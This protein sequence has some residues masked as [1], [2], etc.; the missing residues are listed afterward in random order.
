MFRLVISYFPSTVD[1]GDSR[2][3]QDLQSVGGC[4]RPA[5]QEGV[6]RSNFLSYPFVC[7]TKYPPFCLTIN[8]ISQENTFGTCTVHK[9]PTKQT[10]A[11]EDHKE[12]PCNPARTPAFFNVPE[13]ITQSC[14]EFDNPQVPIQP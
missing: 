12:Y 11:S 9:S 8:W 1:C 6:Y 2:V 10:P 13:R 4:V 7:I 5:G 3:K 14:L